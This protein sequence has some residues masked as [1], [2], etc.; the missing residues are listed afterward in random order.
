MDRPWFPV[1]F[2]GFH[3]GRHV[4]SNVGMVEARQCADFRSVD[5]VVLDGFDGV[6]LLVQHMLGFV[7]AAK[8][9]LSDKGKIVEMLQ[10]IRPPWLV[11]HYDV[12]R[13]GWLGQVFVLVRLFVLVQ[14]FVLTQFAFA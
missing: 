9:S 5:G 2:V 3:P 6:H 13:G 12:A 8:S 14:L 10:Q 7:N 11:H 1:W 4:G